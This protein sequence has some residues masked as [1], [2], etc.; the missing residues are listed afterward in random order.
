VEHNDVEM[1]K[2]MLSGGFVRI[3]SLDDLINYV[4]SEKNKEI[5]FLLCNY[6]NE[7][8][9]FSDPGDEFRL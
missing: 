7:Q 9:G 4:D 3:E 2:V 5:F 1:V 6:K 8:V